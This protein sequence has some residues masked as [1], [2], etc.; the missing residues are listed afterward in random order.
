MP[1]ARQ[2][3]TLFGLFVPAS[4]RR[5]CA[6]RDAVTCLIARELVREGLPADAF[7][8][9]QPAAVTLAT[10]AARTSWASNPDALCEA[11]GYRPSAA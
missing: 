3:A 5:R 6:I 8:E 7:G 9:L 4:G 2:A 11:T 1:A 10:T